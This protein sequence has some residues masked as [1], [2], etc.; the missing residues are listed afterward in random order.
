MAHV[1]EKDGLR[2]RNLVADRA[3]YFFHSFP[4]G[5]FCEGLSHCQ[6][7]AHATMHSGNVAEDLAQPVHRGQGEAVVTCI[8]GFRDQLFDARG[9]AFIGSGNVHPFVVQDFGVGLDLSIRASAKIER[10]ISSRD[11]FLRYRETESACIP[12]VRD[13]RLGMPPGRPCSPSTICLMIDLPLGVRVDR[14]LADRSFVPGHI[15]VSPEGV[16][17][18]VMGS[19]Y[20]RDTKQ[21]AAS[22]GSIPQ[23]RY[24]PDDHERD[25]PPVPAYQPRRD[26]GATRQTA[27][28]GCGVSSL[29]EAQSGRPDC[30]L[31]GLGGRVVLRDDSAGHAEHH[32][33]QRQAATR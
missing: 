4:F 19:T 25:L 1:F 8:L 24:P 21:S 3:K 13:L 10:T 30:C 16:V 20:R 18:A 27:I 6:V 28:L 15:Q 9:E 5:R 26:R 12:D 7:G 33:H 2:L 22:S 23:R 31:T 32:L 29:R 17:E 11:V 14:D